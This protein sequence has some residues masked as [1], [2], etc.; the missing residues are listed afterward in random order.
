MNFWLAKHNVD[1]TSEEQ[2]VNFVKVPTP[3][4]PH[5]PNTPETPKEVKTS[6]ML[7]KTG[8]QTT[9][10]IVMTML[11]VFVLVTLGVIVYK[12]RKA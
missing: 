11:G 2:T 10:S 4:K 3:E 1:L 5:V 9:L 7:P 12:K 8:E 6:A